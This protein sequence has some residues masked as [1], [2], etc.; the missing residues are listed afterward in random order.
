[1]T[2]LLGT[3]EENKVLVIPIMRGQDPITNGP[4]VAVELETP[5]ELVINQE[6]VNSLCDA[7]TT[8][9]TCIDFAPRLYVC[10]KVEIENGTI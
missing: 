10:G 4:G 7:C 1:V 8:R 5:M 3:P 9:P 6:V 2:A